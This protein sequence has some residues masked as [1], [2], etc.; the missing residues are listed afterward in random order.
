M[1]RFSFHFL[2]VVSIAL[3]SYIPSASAAERQLII[4]NWSDY[5]DPALIEKFEQRYGVKVREVYYSSDDNRTEVLQES[6][7]EGYDLILT[8]DSDLYLYA[9]HQWITELD[10]SQIPN[11]KHIS[12]RWREATEAAGQYAV[13]FFWGTTGIIY[14]SDLVKTPITSWQQLFQPAPELQGKVAMIKSSKDLIGMGLKALGYS[15]NSAD[16]DQLK[17][18]E[19]LLL[20]QKPYVA[21]YNS[22]NLDESSTMLS[23]DIVAALMYNGDALML[24][25]LNEHIRYVLPQEGGNIWVDYFTL[26]SK[27]KNVELA[28]AFLNFMNEPENA[29]QMAEYVYYASPNVAAEALLSPDFLTNPVIY[30]DQSQLKSSEFYQ[31]QSPRAQRLRNSI[32]ANV[33][34]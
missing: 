17:Q 18:V 13:P 12:P 9:K 20:E 25:E 26:G 3:L 14:R 28:Y 11:I 21:T 30:P 33:L 27:A 4:L 2:V 24:A 15:A 34:R 32:S 31:R 29:A 19:T 5:M 7:G 23:G 1:F 10:Y 8:S 6:N 22:I 16:R